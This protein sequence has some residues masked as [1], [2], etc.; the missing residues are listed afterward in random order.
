MLS[1]IRLAQNARRRKVES[2][3][4]RPTG[5]RKEKGRCCPNKVTLMP[6]PTVE[7]TRIEFKLVEDVRTG[8]I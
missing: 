2:N 3:E 8:R 7:V 6:K 1:L 5:L 4:Q